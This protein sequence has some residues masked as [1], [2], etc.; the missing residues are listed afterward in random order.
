MIV[1]LA[2]SR[3]FLLKHEPEKLWSEES[4]LSKEAEKKEKSVG[5]MSEIFCL[6]ISY[7]CKQVQTPK[8]AFNS[9]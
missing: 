5:N 1:V 8:I 2:N 3:R 9:L 7:D 6:I 4:T